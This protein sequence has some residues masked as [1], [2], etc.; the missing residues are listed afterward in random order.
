AGLI[1]YLRT[2]SVRI[3][4]EMQTAAASYIAG[5]YGEEYCGTGDKVQKTPQRIQDAHEAIRPTDLALDPK[6]VEGSLARDTYRLYKLIWD[7]FLASQMA[8]AE[9]E[10]QKITVEGEGMSFDAA[11]STLRFAGFMKVYQEED[12]GEKMQNIA[13]LKTGDAVNIRKLDTLQHFTQPP[14]RYTEGT[15]VKA[16]EDNGIGRPSTYAPTITT[17]TARDYA[18][19]EK[20]VLYVTDLGFLV[21]DI[22]KQYFDDVDSVGFTARLEDSLDRVSEGKEEWR[23][24]LR[25]FYTSFEPQ[26]TK[27]M[28][29]LEKVKLEDPV[30]D[31]ICEKCGRNM[32]LK[33]GKFG[34]FYACPGFPE[35][36][37]TKPYFETI[38]ASCPK[39]GGMVYVRKTRKGRTYYGCEHQPE[40]D[41]MSWDRPSLKSCPLCGERLYEKRGRKVSLVCMKESCSYSE[42]AAEE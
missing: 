32:V 42:E 38:D 24:I 5:L 3:S 29:E 7:R 9:Y 35:C 26:V 22:T 12:E 10:T 16:L 20:K 17:L 40:C 4:E 37:N 15:L 6:T 27:A 31:V 36:H 39:C 41:F 30:T 1:T 25:E 34:K 18:A 23:Q 33:S 14:A 21:N 11:G 28:K 8:P 2:D 13:G 19:K